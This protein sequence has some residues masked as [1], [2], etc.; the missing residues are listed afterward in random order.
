[1]FLILYTSSVL[2]Q[3]TTCPLKI[4]NKWYTMKNQKMKKWL[5][6]WFWIGYQKTTKTLFFILSSWCWRSGFRVLTWPTLSIHCKNKLCTCGHFDNLHTEGIFV[7]FP[8]FTL[9]SVLTPLFFKLHASILVVFGWEGSMDFVLRFQTYVFL[10]VSLLC[11]ATWAV[12]TW[13][14][15]WTA[16]QPHLFWLYFN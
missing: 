3:I 10:D 15:K 14:K 9:I 11:Q 8:C 5:V 2:W 4:K 6:I 12:Y 1:M 13:Y 7:F 16:L